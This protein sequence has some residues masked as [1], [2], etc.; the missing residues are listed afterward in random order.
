VRFELP[1]AI[2]VA[3]CIVEGDPALPELRR[4]ARDQFRHQVKSVHCLRD[5]AQLEIGH[6]SFQDLPR[7]IVPSLPERNEGEEAEQERNSHRTFR[8]HQVVRQFYRAG[9]PASTWKDT[10]KDILISPNIDFATAIT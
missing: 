1:A 10:W 8:S 6:G 2:V 4:I 3:P 5:A 9:A 7:L